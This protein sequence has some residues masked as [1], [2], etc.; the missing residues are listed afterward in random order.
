[1]CRRGTPNHVKLFRKMHKPTAKEL[2]KQKLTHTH[3]RKHTFGLESYLARLRQGIHKDYLNPGRIRKSLKTCTQD[4]WWCCYDTA[5]LAS[6]PSYLLTHWSVF[7]GYLCVCVHEISSK[8]MNMVIDYVPFLVIIRPAIKRKRLVGTSFD[9]HAITT[10]ILVQ[11]LVTQVTQKVMMY[12][13]NIRM[14]NT[15]P[16]EKQKNRRK[17]VWH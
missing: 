6:C 15:F 11:Q 10:G 4:C 14:Y 8:V 7:Y 3:S 1:M 12:L 16:I 2:Q 17:I 13:W 5:R 9:N